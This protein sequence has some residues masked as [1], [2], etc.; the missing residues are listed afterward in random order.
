MPKIV[1][2]TD[3]L[4]YPIRLIQETKHTFTVIYGL[5]KSDGLT[6]VEAV[7]ELGACIFHALECMGRI[8][9]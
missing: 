1:W 6:R 8:K 7:K 3:E 4:S 5:Q 9:V 2:S